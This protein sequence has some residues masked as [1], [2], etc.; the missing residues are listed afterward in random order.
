M[1]GRTISHYKILEKLGEGGMGIV[2]KAQDTKLD[3]P[4]AIKFLPRQLA[5]DAEERK[6]FEREAK[7]AAALN[8]PNIATIYAIE[9]IDDP[10]RGNEQFIV[11]EYIDGQD[12]RKYIKAQGGTPIPIDQT[13][14]VVV[15]TA[16][17][18]RTA[19]RKGIVHRDI[20]SANIMMTREGQVKIMD[21][22]L[23]KLGGQTQL[24]KTGTTLGTVAYMS[25]EQGRGDKVDQR[26]DIWSLGIILYELLTGELPFQG[27]YEQAVL[28]SILHEEPESVS[29]YREDIPKELEQVVRKSLT[30]I[31]KDRYQQIDEFLEDLSSLIDLDEIPSTYLRKPSLITTLKS[32]KKYLWISALF[33]LFVI[34]SLIQI[35]RML[36]APETVPS[37]FQYKISI[38][39]LYFENRSGEEDLD[40]ILV[41]MLTTNLARYDGLEVV[42]SQRLFD[43]LKNLGKLDV[44]TI[45][46][47]IATEVAEQ[48]GVE[49]M[50]LGSIIQIG[51]KLRIAS[52]LTDVKTGNIIGSPQ[53]D[54]EKIED[55][56]AMVDKLTEELGGNLA[57]S[58]AETEEA[59]FKIAEVTTT[60]FVAY[61]YYQKGSEAGMRWDSR[62]AIKNFRK[63]IEIDSTFAMA[64]YHLAWIQGAF[65][66]FNP[67]S[68]LSQYRKA[69][70]I[71][72]RHSQKAS[73]R[74]R[75]IIASAKAKFD[76]DILKAVSLSEEFVSRYPN[77]KHALWDLS[78]SYM[79]L[80]NF[81]G[82]IA[83]LER[84]LELDPTFSMVYNL[85]SYHYSAINE[86]EK[87]ISANRKYMALLPDVGNTY[88]AAVDILMQAGRF[89]EALQ[90]CEEGLKKLL[91]DRQGWYSFRTAM[92]YLFQGESDKALETISRVQ[93]LGKR[94]AIAMHEDIGYVH[95]YEGRYKEALAALKK[96]TELALEA[97]WLKRALESYL[98]MAKLLTV[99]G[100]YTE[101][102]SA[103]AEAGKIS[104]QI[105]D[106][107]FNPV[108]IMREYLAGSAMAKKGDYVKAQNRALRIKD[109]VDKQG[110]D[111]YYLNYYHLLLAEI[112]LAQDNGKAALAEL[113][114]YTTMAMSSP[115]QRTM[116][117]ASYALQGKHQE[118]IKHYQSFYNYVVSRL[119]LWG[120][121]PFDY[122]Y[123]R[124]KVNYHL[125]KIYEQQ[126]EISQAVEYYQKTLEQWE[127][128]DTDFLELIDAKKRL[129]ALTITK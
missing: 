105:Y 1:I 100:S 78:D 44:K 102:L 23:A 22:G 83:L 89:D 97:N 34:F 74:E 16:Q 7:A 94:S 85:L 96:H 116:R 121:D 9:E 28:Y 43:I 12:L 72:E 99:Q 53:A 95:M 24:T 58:T 37:T 84:A 51:N 76:R 117:A 57:V 39:V 123:Q 33:S 32:S 61:K 8:H 90:M 29:H 48:A 106:S 30:K 107:S 87:A 114:Q 10:Q 129:A 46:R 79:T 81:D 82:A 6:R 66:I 31:S 80:G 109:F 104:R 73:H 55:V 122:Y 86:H 36:F 103:L 67:F 14:K 40:K 42:S 118:A 70:R 75:L 45:D 119:A 54:G 98:D 63:A 20:K 2:Y 35:G 88:N 111:K 11:M 68:D 92:I 19:H 18:L 59:P 93:E 77:D 64:H 126:G 120:G 108:R 15:Q 101:A 112:Y 91:P 5:A 127:K 26:S 27:D 41:D 124:S 69:M 47:S 13:L 4:V 56:F 110:Y 49:T 52:Q 113:D 125:A 38:A 71:A 115:R 50:L 62:N 3:R 60:S 128:A 25:P 65:G 17:G 21:F